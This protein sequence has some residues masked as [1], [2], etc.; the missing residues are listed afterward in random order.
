[1]WFKKKK[2]I[3][4]QYL[5]ECEGVK[6][7]DV[8]RH[9]VT[10]IR[11]VAVWFRADDDGAIAFVSVGFGSHDGFECYLSEVEPA[12][13]LAAVDLV[14]PSSVEPSTREKQE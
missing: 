12:P 5:F 13:S 10:G 7:G 8:L 6:S 2:P 1:M 3:Q 11:C 4:V 14:Q 9:K